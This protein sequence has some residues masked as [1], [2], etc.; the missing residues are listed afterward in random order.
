M[1]KNI[2]YPYHPK[3]NITGKVQRFSILTVMAMITAQA[4][5]TNTFA[6]GKKITQQ[7][8]DDD[9]PLRVKWQKA[10]RE[11]QRDPNHVSSF[12]FDRFSKYNRYVRTTAATAH[13]LQMLYNYNDIVKER[14]FKNFFEKL[15]SEFW[16]N[17]AANTLAVRNRKVCIEALLV[18]SF[19]TVFEKKGALRILSVASG[20]AEAVIGALEVF[21]AKYSCDVTKIDILL[22]DIDRSALKIAKNTFASR[23][24]YIKFKV[25]IGNVFQLNRIDSMIKDFAPH[26]IEKA[27][28]LDYVSNDDAPDILAKLQSYNPDFFITCNIMPN[29][30]QIVLHSV[31]MWESM[32]YRTPETFIEILERGQFHNPE[33]YLEPYN[34]HVIGRYC[35]NY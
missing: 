4:T 19:S 35:R 2:M 30:E 8:V 16:F 23:F 31:I 1:L 34:I 28:F 20:S 25:Q 14:G 18:D 32:V 21:L 24:P 33:I 15:I 22:V 10:R 9:T 6:I 13:A 12:L 17:Y 29:I 26:V 3:D 27:G 7:Y 5:V 11:L